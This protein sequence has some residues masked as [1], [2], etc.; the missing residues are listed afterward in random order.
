MKSYALVLVIAA[1]LAITI[2]EPQ[3]GIDYDCYLSICVYEN[4]DPPCAACPDTL[5]CQASYSPRKICWKWN[6]DPCGDDAV[7]GP[8]TFRVYRDQTL[9]ATVPCPY[10]NNA[11]C[12][13]RNP[14]EG[15]CFRVGD[16][17][18]DEE[19]CYTYTVK[20]YKEGQ[21]IGEHNILAG[22]C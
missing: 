17:G 1:A 16:S 7:C 11:C 21:Q 22:E 8:D 5:S 4:S 13:D 9:I 3:A 6:G 12:C 15:Q 20:A 18:Y 10:A 2:T 19:E 14:C